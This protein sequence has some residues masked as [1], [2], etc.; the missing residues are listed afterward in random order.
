MTIPSMKRRGSLHGHRQLAVNI[1]ARRT[2]A[3]SITWNPS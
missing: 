1:I 3:N 2:D